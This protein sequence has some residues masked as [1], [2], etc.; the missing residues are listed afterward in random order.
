MSLSPS[1]V[2]VKGSSVNLTCR[3]DANPAAN[4]TWYKEDEK[5]PKAVGQTFAIANFSA[6]HT[7]AYQ[8]EVQ[9]RRGRHRST[10]HLVIVQLSG[11]DSGKLIFH[12]V[13]GHLNSRIFIWSSAPVYQNMCSL[14]WNSHVDNTITHLVHST[15]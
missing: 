12:T 8:C 13:N 1:T 2:I 7:G 9:N 15:I 6:E 4:Y 5:S 3:S 10:V 11:N 14:F